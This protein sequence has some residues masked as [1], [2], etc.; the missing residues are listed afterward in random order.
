MDAE[1]DGD[2]LEAAANSQWQLLEDGAELTPHARH[3]AIIAAGK[4]LY[5]HWYN[6]LYFSTSDNSDPNTNGRKY[7][8][9]WT[10]KGVKSWLRQAAQD[11]LADTFPLG[12][13]A[14]VQ[15]CSGVIAIFG[16]SYSGSTLVNSVLGAHPYIYGG[17][18]LELLLREEGRYGKCA[19]CSSACRFWTDDVR[20]SLTAESFYHQISRV[21]GRSFIVDSSKAPYW[22]DQILPHY[23]SLP[24]VR[25]LLVKHPIRHVSSFLERKAIEGK[26]SESWSTWDRV[27]ERMRDNYEAFVLPNESSVTPKYNRN[28]YRASVDLLLRY[29]DVVASP[30]EALQPI[31]GLLNLDYHPRMNHWPQVEHHHIGGNVG[32]M[33]QIANHQSALD[34]GRRK[35]LQRG[36]FMDN[37]YSEILDPD[38]VQQ[39]LQHPDALWMCERFG[40]GEAT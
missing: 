15:T 22:F 8:L 20:A 25:V 37:S 9:R 26:V 19:V 40:Y 1:A 17:S 16:L 7:T 18:E 12:A 38:I 21:F 28:S 4:G 6:K 35:Y 23:P 13:R 3:D 29:E 14:D 10:G 11:A 5:S 2:R 31:L 30:V 24:V 27:L 32:P 34:T 33:A 39:I 36:I